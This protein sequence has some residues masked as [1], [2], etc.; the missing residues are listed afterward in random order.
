M[1]QHAKNPLKQSR[2]A[3]KETAKGDCGWSQKP[4]MPPAVMAV[5]FN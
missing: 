2:V 3:E 1:R 4:Y 5:Y